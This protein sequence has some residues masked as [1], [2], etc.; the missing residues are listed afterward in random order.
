MPDNRIV[1]IA[2]FGGSF[3][4]I[5]TGLQEKYLKEAFRFIQLGQVSGIRISTRPDY[6]QQE[7]LDLLKNYGVTTIE[8]GAQGRIGLSPAADAILDCFNTSTR[9]G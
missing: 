9:R 3:T 4:G 6:I 5:D 2:F 1:D 7:K 8:L